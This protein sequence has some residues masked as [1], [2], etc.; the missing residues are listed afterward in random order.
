MSTSVKKP[1]VPQSGTVKGRSGS[2]TPRTTAAASAAA[3]PGSGLK[4][5]TSSSKSGISPPISS[6]AAHRPSSGSIT[7]PSAAATGPAPLTT[8]EEFV[9]HFQLRLEQLSKSWKTCTALDDVATPSDELIAAVCGG[10]MRDGKPSLVVVPNE[11]SVLV[12]AAESAP[13]LATE[14]LIEAGTS[15]R[16]CSSSGLCNEITLPPPVSAAGSRGVSTVTWSSDTSWTVS[17]SDASLSGNMRVVHGGASVQRGSVALSTRASDNAISVSVNPRAASASKTSVTACSLPSTSSSGKRIETYTH[18][19]DESVTSFTFQDGSTCKTR[20]SSASNASAKC[21]V[22]IMDGIA[23][24]SG[25]VNAYTRRFSGPA[26]SLKV[27][28]G[29]SCAYDGGW[30]DSLRHT[31]GSSNGLWKVTLAPQ[32]S[33]SGS[34]AVSAV[35]YN[36]QWMK[37]NRH[38]PNGRLSIRMCDGGGVHIDADW[39]HGELNRTA[40]V[41]SIT[42]TETIAKCEFQ[43]GSM[44]PRVVLVFPTGQ[45][46]GSW[47]SSK[48]VQE[49]AAQL[50]SATS[51]DATAK[52]PPLAVLSTNTLG[53]CSTLQKVSDA[54]GAVDALHQFVV[55][56]IVADQI[57]G[58]AADVLASRVVTMLGRQVAATMVANKK[59]ALHEA[60]CE[61]VLEASKRTKQALSAEE[62]K[63]SEIEKRL[64]K[65]RQDRDASAVAAQRAAAQLDKESQSIAAL[66][67]D[68]AGDDKGVLADRLRELTRQK[69]DL[70]P[71]IAELNQELTK[72]RNDS[73]KVAA[74]RDQMNKDIKSANS[75]AEQCLERS[76][77]L[78]AQVDGQAAKVLQIEADSAAIVEKLEAAKIAAQQ[79]LTDAQKKLAADGEDMGSVNIDGDDS[80]EKRREHIRELKSEVSR[81]KTQIEELDALRA[82]EEAK[83]QGLSKHV[84]GSSKKSGAT[85]DDIEAEIRRLTE[86]L[87][88][89]R[90]ALAAKQKEHEVLE[91]ETQKRREAIRNLEEQTGNANHDDAQDSESVA[92]REKVHQLQ[93]ECDALA[94]S[95]SAVRTS[96]NKKIGEVERLKEDI[97]ALEHRIATQKSEAAA[98][99]KVVHMQAA[100]PP[101]EARATPP[102]ASPPP[103]QSTPPPDPRIAELEAALRTVMAT[104]DSLRRK[105]DNIKDRLEQLAKQKEGLEFKQ[106]RRQQEE[107]A[108]A[109]MRAQQQ[110]VS[111]SHDNA[112]S[113]DGTIPELKALLAKMKEQN[114]QYDEENTTLRAR[115]DNI[116]LSLEELKKQ[117]ANQ[118]PVANNSS[119]D[120]RTK[121][122]QDEVDAREAKITA[123]RSELKRVH[124]LEAKIQSAKE[125]IST[126]TQSAEIR[127]THVAQ[128]AKVEQ[129][130]SSSMNFARKNSSS[131]R[132][133]F[134]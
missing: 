34:T 72:L 116:L 134:F 66:N 120:W 74:R 89:S 13:T 45:F 115:H 3:R 23:S 84:G 5:D 113:F 67:S 22:D 100:Q 94:S 59:H 87:E 71:L 11:V 110:H 48:S 57:N 104:Q 108:D 118:N 114:K 50:V 25:D 128:K 97:E 124:L 95:I 54:V 26:G 117:C 14:V 88:A 53:T 28:G 85:V 122:L 126:L 106:L 70:E 32:G 123:L 40:T 6:Q 109:A 60:S 111:S 17:S 99:V 58:P 129:E 133:A 69:Q 96:M 102:R 65:A 49:V 125:T 35:E 76:A 36:G 44:G 19:G 39:E 107:A 47:S 10:A 78:D 92:H 68:V 43:S 73:K 18:V 63:L 46:S 82:A 16:L 9:D 1:I 75:E 12:S 80:S 86:G 37:D 98:A 64:N 119:S 127:Q 52:V 77:A 101:S 91:T 38:G 121:A 24:Y 103:R 20:P 62:Q 15:K 90:C 29:A 21:V 7:K 27:I 105:T 79:A 56:P 42:N 83:L 55:R 41:S 8:V 51:C 81:L 130:W 93:T 61:G 33:S 4:K 31:A 2:L 30:V 132:S 131:G 112:V